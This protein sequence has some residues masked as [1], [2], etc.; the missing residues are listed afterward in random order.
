MD[1]RAAGGRGVPPYRVPAHAWLISLCAP[2]G[3]SRTPLALGTRPWHGAAWLLA[4]AFFSTVIAR[5]RGRHVRQQPLRACAAVQGHVHACV[6]SPAVSSAQV[7]RSA[8][9]TTAADKATRACLHVRDGFAVCDHATANTTANKRKSTR[10]QFA[11][12]VL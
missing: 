1:G 12:T 3:R 9:A 7:S 10:G 5:A 2:L 11:E 8:A 6:A 4:A